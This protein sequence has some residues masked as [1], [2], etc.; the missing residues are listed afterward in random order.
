MEC[1]IAFL[2]GRSD[3]P[4]DQERRNWL[5][6]FAN[7]RGTPFVDLTESIHAHGADAFI[8]ANWHLSPLGHRV[9]ADELQPF[10]AT[11]ILP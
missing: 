11:E 1:G 5:K 10:I 3:T 7:G 2:P 6:Q 4:D 9:V 8:P